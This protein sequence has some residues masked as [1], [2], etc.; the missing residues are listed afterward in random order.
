MAS[1]PIV[2]VR[3]GESEA[4]VFLHNHDPDA[5]TKI[6]RLGDPK[7]STLG[8]EQA[9]AT[10]QA[11]IKSFNEIGNPRVFVLCSQFTRAVQTGQY[12]VDN[13]ESLL[14]YT[15]TN[16]LLEYTPPKKNLSQIHLDSGLSH[17]HTWDE[18]KSRIISFCDEWVTTPPHQPIVVFGHSMFISCLVT[19][20]SSHRKFFPEKD[21]MFFRY[22]NC[23]ITTL[24]WDHERN[25]WMGD[26]I[27]SITHLPKKLVT[28]THTPFA[29]LQNE[30]NE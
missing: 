23:S 3:H 7:L 15:E 26:H 19:Y 10:C 13:Y 24:V 22:P 2:F 14:G 12:F 30:D 18:F 11:L 4:N 9:K 28:G 21:Q 8:L 1:H 17:D 6:N 29:T 25:R 20:I 16:K 27:A 5:G